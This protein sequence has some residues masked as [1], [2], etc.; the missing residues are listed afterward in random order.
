MAR[1][2]EADRAGLVE[3]ASNSEKRRKAILEAA[4]SVFLKSG[5][6]GA[7]MDEI[8]A[9][10]QVSKQTV[11]KQFTSK[12]SLFVQIV[13]SMT[14]TAGDTVHKN[15]PEFAENEEVSE[16]L[17]SYAFRQLTVVLTPPIMQLR[18]LV[19][20]E[21]SRFPELARILYER[22][23][24][25]AIETFASVL[26]HLAARGLLNIDDPKTAASHFN[27]LVMSEPLNKAMLLGDEAIPKPAALRRHAAECLRVFMSAYGTR[28]GIAGRGR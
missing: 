3:E 21:V 8:A 27:W 24:Q 13:S 26:E 16:Y 1:S 22:G 14:D 4:M 19:I 11:Y 28:P 9:I 17:H 15:V 10:A 2:L 20:G 5:Y 6:L 7:S 12:E 23:P 18:R 25:R